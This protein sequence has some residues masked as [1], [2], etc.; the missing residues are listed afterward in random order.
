M[1]IN[2][3]EAEIVKYIFEMYKTKGVI[4][5]VKSLNSRGVKTKRGKTFNYDAVRYIINNPIYIGKIRWGDDIL[6]DI[7]QKD[8]ETF[9]DK[10]TWYTVQ[11]VQDS[12]KI[13][14]VR[15]QNFS[16]SLMC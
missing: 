4:S 8:F 5:I 1:Y 16:Y 10:D 12:R 2:H 13:G 9:I 6:T 11:Q 14:K 7:A 3:T 15:L